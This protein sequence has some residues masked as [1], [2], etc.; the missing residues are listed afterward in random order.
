MKV[1]PDN[2]ASIPG[3]SCFLGSWNSRVWAKRVNCMN[4]W[5]RIGRFDVTLNHSRVCCCW[6]FL[7]AG[8]YGSLYSLQNKCFLVLFLQFSFV[9]TTFP[10][11]GNGVNHVTFHSTLNYRDHSGTYTENATVY[12]ICFD[13]FSGEF[14]FLCFGVYLCYCIRA[15]PSDYLEARYVSWA[16]YNET[17][18]S[19]LLHITRYSFTIR[20]DIY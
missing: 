16:I 15:A 6:F 18:A 11:A 17:V 5:T 13:F 2:F 8:P 7:G 20:Y 9:Y 4:G 10:P 12:L 19:A 1:H 14:L 3:A